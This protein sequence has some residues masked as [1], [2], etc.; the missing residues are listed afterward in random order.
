MRIAFFGTP[1]PAV[2][3]LSALA[4][5]DHEVVA[6][7]T[8]PDRPA[9][10][11]RAPRPSVVKERALEL[12][13]PVLTPEDASDTEFIDALAATS[14]DLGVVVA[15][16]EILGRRLLELPPNGFVNIHYSLLPELRGAAPVYGALRQRFERT[17]VTVQYMARKLDAGDILLQRELDIAEDDNRGTLTDRLTETGVPALMDA[18]GLIQ[19]GTAPRVAQEHELA[20]YVGRVETA[21]CRIDWSEPAAEVR[22]LVRA[23]TPWPGAWCELDGARVKVQYVSV[24]QNVLRQEGRPGR[25]VEIPSGGGPIVLT[26][27]G[28]VQIRALQPAGKRAMT[29]EEFLRGARLRPG[30]VFE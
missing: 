24:V 20:T 14:P 27:R 13:L 6:V 15:Y 3:Y 17:G 9:G 30:D 25:I 4:S 11:G 1:P 28:S 12:E 29:G 19:A 2:P 22:A 21:D 5:S 8:Q 10:R 23:C 16:G 7:V 18:V 26:G